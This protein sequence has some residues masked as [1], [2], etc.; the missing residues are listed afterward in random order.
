MSVHAIQEALKNYSGDELAQAQNMILLASDFE[1]AE[2]IAAMEL[3]SNEVAI[4][5]T[6]SLGRKAERFW[7]RHGQ[8]VAA[9]AIGA[10]IGDW[11]GD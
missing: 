11:V 9:V 4:R 7:N 6:E 3:V 1:P 2:R 5:R 8:T 10:L